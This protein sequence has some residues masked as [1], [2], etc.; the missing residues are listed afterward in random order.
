M[1]RAVVAS[2]NSIFLSSHSSFAVFGIYFD[3]FSL[4]FR[5][6]FFFRHNCSVSNTTVIL[7]RLCVQIHVRPLRGCLTDT[8][9]SKTRQPHHLVT[10]HVVS[11]APQYIG[12]R[13]TMR[14]SSACSLSLTTIFS[15]SVHSFRQSNPVTCDVMSR[16]A[17]KLDFRVLKCSI[18]FWGWF[19]M[20]D[21]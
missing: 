4:I 10:S 21:P 3:F 6:F 13:N 11:T 5:T 15:R 18:A 17:A 16:Q 12:L 7:R 19:L 9:W 1:L 20:L 14:A 8:T 2:L